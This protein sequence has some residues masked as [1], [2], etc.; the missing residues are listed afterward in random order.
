MAVYLPINFIGD[1]AWAA[2]WHNI[3]L[4]FANFYIGFLQVFFYWYIFFY[5]RS[6]I[7]LCIDP[8]L[9]GSFI[10]YDI[11]WKELF[12]YILLWIFYILW[13][14]LNLDPFPFFGSFILY[15]IYW[16]FQ[17]LI[18]TY[19]WPW[20]TIFLFNLYCWLASFDYWLTNHVLW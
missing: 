5:F 6:F 17:R 9:F 20:N 16:I 14:I 2:L 15:V 7:A 3:Y 12:A 10:F 13:Y 4:F 11:Y 18:L 19:A 8:F 1:I